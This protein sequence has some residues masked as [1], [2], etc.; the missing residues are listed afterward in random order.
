V[1]IIARLDIKGEN[2]IKGIQ[3]EGLRVIGNPYEYAL[4]YYL[5]GIDEII[6]IIVSQQFKTTI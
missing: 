2:L 3:L 4:K 6:Y 5:D 1:R